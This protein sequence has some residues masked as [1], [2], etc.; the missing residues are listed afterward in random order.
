ML[1]KFTVDGKPITKY[2][3]KEVSLS[4]SPKIQPNLETV[5]EQVRIPFK[6]YKTIKS[7]DQANLNRMYEQGKYKVLEKGKL[8]EKKVEVRALQQEDVD[9]TLIQR[10]TL[11]GT[12]KKIQESSVREWGG[13][14]KT[15]YGDV[16][17]GGQ[18]TDVILG[19]LSK[20]VL[21]T[22]LSPLPKK[23][24][25]KVNYKSMRQ[26]DRTSQWTGGSTSGNPF[27]G[28]G[29]GKTSTPEETGTY[30]PRTGTVTV[31]KSN[32]ISSPIKGSAKKVMKDYST[33]WKATKSPYRSAYVGGATVGGITVDT[34]SGLTPKDMIK[35]GVDTGIRIDTGTQIKIDTKIDTGMKQ[36]SVQ[37]LNADTMSRIKSRSG[38]RSKIKLDTGLK[39]QQMVTT[40]QIPLLRMSMS[41]QISR[42]KPLP[43]ILPKLNL[44]DKPAKRGKRGKKAGFIGNVRLDNIMG[45]YKRKEITYGARKV[46]KLERQDARLTAKTPNRISMPASSLLKTK[47]KKK[48]KTEMMFGNKSNDEFGGFGLSKSKKTKRKKTTKTKRI[49]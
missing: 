43:I 25:P 1:K 19:S 47:K 30:D 34:V 6:D 13:T 27:T 48:K 28:K 8:V 29:R 14:K 38:I 16:E 31:N 44:E 12:G 45:M 2:V 4:V 40:A 18:R 41:R 3:S 15:L 46:T 24:P 5:G 20:K 10:N 33:T 23:T 11:T 37:K 32:I 26:D 42:K 17:V 7:L 9:K 21:T 35:T 36:D 39:Q 49:L 22:K